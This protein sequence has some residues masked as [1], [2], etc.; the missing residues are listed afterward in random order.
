G[1]RQGRRRD[2]RSGR[3]RRARPERRAGRAV[4]A[5][6][7]GVR[8][9][10]LARPEPAAGAVARPF[11]TSAPR[12]AWLWRYV[13]LTKP[14]IVVLLLLTTLAPMIVAADGW[15]GWPLVLATLLG[16]ALAAGGGNPLN[17]YLHPH[18]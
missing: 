1:G 5:G 9:M 4:A 18:I 15:P 14:R 16:G 2:G 8:E 13:S 12:T 3:G 6:A 17:C 10:E 7:V 11:A